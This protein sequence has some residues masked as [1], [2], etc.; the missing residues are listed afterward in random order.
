M[1]SHKLSKDHNLAQNELSSPGQQK[2]LKCQGLSN[3]QGLDS[4]EARGAM[5]EQQQNFCARK[6]RINTHKAHVHTDTHTKHMYTLTQT[7][8]H[9]AHVHTD[10]H[11][12]HIYALTHT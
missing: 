2:S 11:T 4:D 3:K 1:K 12:K 8:T 10:T 7:Y 6:E 5:P 9:K